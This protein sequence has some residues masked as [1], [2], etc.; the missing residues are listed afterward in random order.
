ML[1]F[2][3]QRQKSVNT[4]LVTQM[5][6]WDNNVEKIERLAFL[7]EMT[8]KLTRLNFSEVTGLTPGY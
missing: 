2:R 4:Q 7:V 5:K 8:C 6:V 3:C 1:I